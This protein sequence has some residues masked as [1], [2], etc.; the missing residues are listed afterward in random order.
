MG[1]ERKANDLNN[2][3]TATIKEQRKKERNQLSEVVV[4]VAGYLLYPFEPL[5]G[6]RFHHVCEPAH[7]HEQ[8]R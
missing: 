6:Q 1:R 3:T 5:G 7:V 4:Q 8:Q 2:G